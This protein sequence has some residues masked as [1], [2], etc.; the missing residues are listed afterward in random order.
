MS[1]E[2]PFLPRPSSYICCT[3]LQG[4]S[5]V[6]ICSDD[7]GCDVEEVCH[8]FDANPQ[9]GAY[10]YD[11]LFSAFLTIFQVPETR[12]GGPLLI[13]VL[14]DHRSHVARVLPH[15]RSR[16]RVGAAKCTC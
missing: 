12:A 10:S 1:T 8:Y 3:A 6:V 5:Q 4:S 7:S 9:S 14:S 11:N 15:R 2:P 16:S 13:P